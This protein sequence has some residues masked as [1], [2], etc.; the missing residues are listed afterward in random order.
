MVDINVQDTL[1]VA[2]GLCAAKG[3]FAGVCENVRDDLQPLRLAVKNANLRAF[4]A[5]MGLLK[6]SEQNQHILCG[7]R[8]Y[9]RGFGVQNER[10][11][12]FSRSKSPQHTKRNHAKAQ[13]IILQGNTE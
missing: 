6:E 9:I 11:H 1:A 4:I 8:T 12:C 2:V 7:T 5:Y 13:S 3:Y 10:C